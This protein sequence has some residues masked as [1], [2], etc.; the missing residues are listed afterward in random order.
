MDPIENKGFMRSADPK[1]RETLKTKV[2][3]RVLETLDLVQ[4]QRMPIQELR[5]ECLRKI[6][7]LL[8]AYAAA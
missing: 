5:D 8:S 7:G 3:A 2:H 1:F 4:A 6:D